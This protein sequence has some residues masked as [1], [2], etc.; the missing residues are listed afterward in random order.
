[1]KIEEIALQILK[2]GRLQDKLIG[3]D[4]P[5]QGLDFSTRSLDKVCELEVPVREGV[6]SYR[7]PK[8]QIKLSRQ[9]EVATERGKL[10]HF[11]ANH[12]LLALE[13]MAWALLKFSDA[14]IEFKK[15]VYRTL[16][17]EQKHLSL[18]LERMRE[19]G[20][21][22]GDFPLNLYFWN[23][24]KSSQNPMDYVVRMSLT[25]EQANL[26]FAQEQIILMSE[27]DDFKT[28]QV[29]QKIHD[30]EV[31]HVQN[32][33]KWF[34]LWK[35]EQ[36][37]H[38]S[39]WELYKKLLPFPMSAR[40]AR[41]KYFS[42]E[43]RVLVGFDSE[44]IEEV[45]IV[46][47]SRGRV[48]DLYFFNP[49]CEVECSELTLPNTVKEK[50]LD[51]EP[52][53]VWLGLE[54]DVV[55]QHRK[56]SLEWRKKVFEIKQEFPEVQTFAQVGSQDLSSQALSAEL[57]RP[58]NQLKSWGYSKSSD[59]LRKR[60]L[61]QLKVDTF[62][63]PDTRKLL[64]SKTFWGQ[65]HLNS[66]W[67]LVPGRAVYTVED[68]TAHA[69]NFPQVKQWILKSNYSTSGRGH[70]R[71]KPHENKNLDL[72]H[73]KKSKSYWMEPELNKVFDF[74]IQV[75]IPI[76]STPAKIYPPRFFK[77]DSQ[78]QYQGAYLGESCHELEKQPYFSEA[79][80]LLKASKEALNYEVEKIIQVLKSYQ[81][82]GPVGVDALV[83]LDDSGALKIHPRVEVNVRMTMG[84]VALEIESEL[85]SNKKSYSKS[86]SGIWHWVKNK[87]FMEQHQLLQDQLGNRYFPTTPP[88]TSLQ[89]W[90]YVVL[91]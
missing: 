4:L 45:R 17:E 52:L 31:R 32:G 46:G 78:W 27:V 84:R 65:Q 8:T 3:A 54:S 88:Q 60:M 56:L 79:K 23:T 39:D 90:T 80:T 41:G 82:V 69:K 67:G 86:S 16:Q 12:E 35:Q 47:G 81:Y 2:G 63:T 89:T 73:F 20:V 55:L 13:T 50:L 83:Y 15:S 74:S 6:L 64:Y 28:S 40:R 34:R 57:N 30:D 71:W 51:L 36:N 62:V 37:L 9:L 10:L 87:N 58:W 7:E 14:S 85:K 44:F 19:L 11:F 68:V 26:D 38:D 5:L 1:M 61:P 49:E 75:E 18:Y 24:L 48:P 76:T 29:L 22:L 72:E 53:L 42:L 21:D 43:S 33:L 59:E 70:L 91:D 66:C 25:F 77:V